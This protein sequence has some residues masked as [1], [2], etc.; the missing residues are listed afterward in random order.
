MASSKRPKR[1]RARSPFLLSHYA[2]TSN[3]TEK[4][5][6]E[7]ELHFY[8]RRA[9]V[10]A[11][12][13]SNLPQA[14]RQKVGDVVGTGKSAATNDHTSGDDDKRRRWRRPLHSLAL[15]LSPF[16]HSQ[17]AL[18]TKTRAPSSSPSRIIIAP[19]LIADS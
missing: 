7:K 1:A 12:T 13:R 9:S 3:E 18:S 6:V 15:S 2:R 11:K 5:K 10:R 16:Y 19:L 17:S 4:K 8:F 14:R